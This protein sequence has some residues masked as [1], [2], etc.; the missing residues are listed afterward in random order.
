MATKRDLY[1][2]LTV[3]AVSISLLSFSMAF[4]GEAGAYTSTSNVIASVSV[5]KACFISLGTGSIFFGSIAPGSSTVYTVNSVSDIDTNGNANANILVEGNDLTSGALDIGVS[6]TVWSATNVLI[7]SGTT[8]TNTL[9]D[10]H[11]VVY[12]SGGSTNSIFFGLTVPAGQATAT[13]A[14][15]YLLENSC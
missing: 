3:L 14:A 10:T 6:N 1:A 11:V 7:G 8:L 5:P 9:V 4:M 15:N 12:S 13:Y 2:I